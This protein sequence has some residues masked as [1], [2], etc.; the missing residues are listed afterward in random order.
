MQGAF[1]LKQWAEQNNHKKDSPIVEL[2]QQENE[3]L[4]HIKWLEGNETNGHTTTIRIALPV[5]TW[6]NL[7]EG[8]DATHSQ[9]SKVTDSCGMLEARSEIDTDLIELNSH[10][11]NFR[12]MEARAHI[13]GMNNE[14]IKT[15]FYG[16]TRTYPNNFMGLSPRYSH[17][18]IPNVIDADTKAEK[19]NFT[20]IW[21][22]VWGEDTV[23]GIF[24]KGTSAGMQHEDLGVYDALDSNSR[25]YRATGDLFKWKA[26]LC[27]RDWR[28]VVRI[29]NINIEEGGALSD[30]TKLQEL[31][32]K[33]KNLIPSSKRRRLTWYLN[34]Q[35]LNLLELEAMSNKSTYLRYD[36]YLDSHNI[37][38]IHGMPVYAC[39]AITTEETKLVALNA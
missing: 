5:P 16:D 30:G 36:E 3:I 18:N 2:M 27:V 6:R 9:I 13:E 4:S 12:L 28:C 38:K 20:S 8:V 33:A 25:P 14:F 7:Y 29:A 22:V 23:H 15:L 34:E 31:T 32:I 19:S 21:G 24:P 10:I 1:T 26:G 11:E 37:L 17:S 39:N 35:V